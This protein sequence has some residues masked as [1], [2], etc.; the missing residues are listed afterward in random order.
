MARKPN[1]AIRAIDAG[2]GDAAPDA[3]YAIKITGTI[4]LTSRLH[5]RTE[6]IPGPAPFVSN[7]TEAVMIPAACQRMTDASC[8]PS[9]I[10]F[11]MS[12][13]SIISCG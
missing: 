6:T 4:D 2:G 11:S 8:F 7:P 9:L 12:A 3:A 5:S 10:I 1:T 13:G